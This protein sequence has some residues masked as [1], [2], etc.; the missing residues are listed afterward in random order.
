MR[1]ARTELV[2]GRAILLALVA[3][4]ILPFLSIFVTA[5]HPSGAAPGGLEWPADPQWGNFLEAFDVANMSSLLASSIFIVVAVVL[6]FVIQTFL[7]RIYVI[8]SAS[9][10]RTLHGCSGCANDRVAVDKLTYR[11][12]DPAPGDVVVFR[13]PLTRHCTS[14][15]ELEHEITVTVMHE[16][17]HFFGIDEERLHELGWG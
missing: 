4:T 1:V 6:T 3:I 7:G 17:G 14:R 10:E 2:A 9:M 12:S 11:F 8:P 16:V 13:G 15:A 5:L